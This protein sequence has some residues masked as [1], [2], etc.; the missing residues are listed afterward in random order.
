MR[1][2]FDNCCYNR[3]YDDQTQIRI[4]LETQAKLYIQKLIVERKVDLVFSYISWFENDMHPHDIKRESIADFFQNAVL[5]FDETHANIVE[6]H[7][8]EIMNIGIKQKDALHIACAVNAHCDYFITTD[9]E[10]IKK[11]QAK[12]IIVI[13]P[14]NFIKILEAQNA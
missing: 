9:D 5:F 8:K 7:A 6:Q 14:I 4:A 1:I 2:Y 10:I 12:D 11:Y 3:P 13:N